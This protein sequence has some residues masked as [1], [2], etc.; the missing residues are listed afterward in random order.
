MDNDADAVFAEEV[1]RINAERGTNLTAEGILEGWGKKDTRWVARSL[2]NA[3]ALGLLGTIAGLTLWAGIDISASVGTHVFLLTVGAVSLVML[4]FPVRA[5]WRM[6]RDWHR[7]IKAMD[8][9]NR[10]V[11][12]RL[13]AREQGWTE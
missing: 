8:E 11:D 3:T 6:I 1:E 9:I 13:T 12:A 2:L 10:R 5:E 7:E 4:F